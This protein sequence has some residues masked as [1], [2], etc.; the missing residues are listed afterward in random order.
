VAHY[1]AAEI[2]AMPSEAQTAEAALAGLAEHHDQSHR[3]IQAGT[4]AVH[5]L[6]PAFLAHLNLL[7]FGIPCSPS[8]SL[9]L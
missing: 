3:S 1:L 4:L 2:A 8:R 7:E 6:A 5:D 9:L